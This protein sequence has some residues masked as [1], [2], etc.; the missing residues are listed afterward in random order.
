MAPFFMVTITSSSLY[1]VPERGKASQKPFD[2]IHLKF[3]PSFS[4]SIPLL[5][6]VLVLLFCPSITP[7]DV[8]SCEISPYISPPVGHSLGNR[9]ASAHE[10]PNHY[11]F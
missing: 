5:F 2:V 3:H 10:W 8:P 1:K 9:E 6:P 11:Q 4:S 7:P